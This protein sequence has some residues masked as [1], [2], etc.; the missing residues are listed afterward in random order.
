M[1]AHLERAT[2]IIARDRPSAAAARSGRPNRGPGAR[3][4]HRRA[5]RARD[6][7]SP[8][9]T[10]ATL[11]PHWDELAKREKEQDAE[12]E[13][14]PLPARREGAR[15]RRSSSP[16]SRRRASS[17]ATSR[18]QRRRLQSILERL[19]AGLLLLEEKGKNLVERLSELRQK[20]HQSETRAV[21][22]RRSSSGSRASGRDRRPAQGATT[23]SSASSAGRP[24][25]SKK[26]RL[27]ADEEL[28]ADH[29]RDPSARAQG[30]RGRAHSSSSK[31]EQALA[32]A[33]LEAGAARRA[34]RADA[35]AAQRVSQPRC[36]RGAARLEQLDARLSHAPRKERRA[37]RLRRRQARPRPRDRRRDLLGAARRARRGARRDARTRRGRPRVRLRH[38]RRSRGPSREQRELPGLVGPARGAHRRARALRA[39][40]R[41][42]PRRG[43]LRVLVVDGRRR[44]AIAELPARRDRRRDRRSSRS[45]RPARSPTLPAG[46][47]VTRVDRAVRGARCDRRVEALLGDVSSSMI[48]RR[49]A[50]ASRRNARPHVRDARRR[51]ASG[52]TARSRSAGWSPTPRAC[53]RAS[54][55]STS[56]AT[57]LERARRG[58][59]RGR[60]VRRRGRRGPRRPHSRT[61]SS[62]ARSSRASAGEHDSLREEVGRLEAA[63]TQ[64][65]AEVDARGRARSLRRSSGSTPRTART[66]THDRRSIDASTTPTLERARGELPPRRARSATRASATR[67]ASTSG[68]PHARSR[69]QPSPSARSTS[70]VRSHRS[71]ANSTELEGTVAQSRETEAGARA[72]P[73]AHPADPRPLRGAAGARRALGRQAAG[74]RAFRAG[75]LRVAARRPSTTRRT[76][77][78]TRPGRDRRRNERR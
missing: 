10:C 16:C 32:A 22:R 1:D 30:A 21:A 39:A 19:N 8:S 11:Q 78:A 17:S 55:A 72:A 33:R 5:P 52:R 29:R 7:R 70:S 37:R 13:L 20:L 12:I 56:S 27:A 67:R 35:R 18:E 3:R 60:S 53:S 59:R 77:C 45:T 42:R 43:P 73:R 6:S 71:T 48:S 47:T 50:E 26:E 65:D 25:P 2:D 63:L 23:R 74:P 76:P 49:G 64:L 75:R 57:R 54:D 62:S 9:T 40:R 46:T 58:R 28:S 44:H 66:R 68:S 61:P 38:R 14:A 51:G 34:R 36:P 41:A 4:A 69:S 24:R 15:A 31:L